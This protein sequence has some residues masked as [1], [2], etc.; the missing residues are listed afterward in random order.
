M[1]ECEE[2][3]SLGL[4]SAIDGIPDVLLLERVMETWIYLYLA[5][6]I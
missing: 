4:E 5:I 1:G 3:T 6:F 2:G